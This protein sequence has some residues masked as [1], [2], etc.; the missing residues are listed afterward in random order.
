MRRSRSVGGGRA[1]GTNDRRL[2]RRKSGGGIPEGDV[3]SRVLQVLIGP[4]MDVPLFVHL[5]V[6]RQAVHLV[7][8]HFEADAR[9]DLV[10]A[11]RCQP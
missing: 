3:E 7:N 9:V 2:G 8:E 1:G 11:C 6:V 10:G 5:V 4:L